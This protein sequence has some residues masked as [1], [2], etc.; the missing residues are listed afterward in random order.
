MQN[1]VIIELNNKPL[2]S[3]KLLKYNA[4]TI[5]WVTNMIIMILLNFELFIY[6]YCYST[7]VG[8]SKI[9]FSHA[10]TFDI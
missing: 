7:D 1:I 6:H 2:I 5:S 10:S 8:N 4:K 3:A 9:I